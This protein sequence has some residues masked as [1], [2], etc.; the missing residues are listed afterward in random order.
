MLRS[1]GDIEADADCVW[2]LLVDVARWPEWGPSV[3][4]VEC[5]SRVIGPGVTGRV[6]T[7]PGLWL[8]FEITHWEEGR[9]WRW[10]VGGVAATGHRVVVRGPGRC[11]LVFEVPAWAPFYLPVCALALRRIARIASSRRPA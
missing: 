5:P 10:R 8:D 7:A 11:E 3:Q 2:R 9:Y 1:R 4:A 6:Q